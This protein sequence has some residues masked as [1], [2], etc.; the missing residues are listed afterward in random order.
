MPTT[1]PNPAPSPATG[2]TGGEIKWE[3]H[4]ADDV[5]AT[6]GPEP[7]AVLVATRDSIFLSSARGDFR[8]PRAAISKVGRGN[9]YPWIFSA[10]RFHHAIAGLPRELQFKPLRARPRDLRDRLRE[11]GYPVA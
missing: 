1:D 4:F 7:R 6:Y 9:L 3:G 10:V 11:L 5:G 8:L 2:P